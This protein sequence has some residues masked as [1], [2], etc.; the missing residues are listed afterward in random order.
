M[1]GGAVATYA[2]LTFLYLNWPAVETAS[3][4]TEPFGDEPLALPA[5]D[6]LELAGSA[7]A[8]AVEPALPRA[9]GV[10]VRRRRVR[11][12]ARAWTRL[13]AAARQEL[14][15]ICVIYVASRLLPVSY[16]HLTLPTTER[17]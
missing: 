11:T 15:W 10:S 12:P 9:G 3:E 1:I 5:F 6:E 14:L 17:V 16:T 8:A 4:S 2:V 7:G 13:S